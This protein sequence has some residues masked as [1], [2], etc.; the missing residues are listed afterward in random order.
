MK[1]RVDSIVA[2]V[3][4]VHIEAFCQTKVLTVILLVGV[5]Y[6][7]NAVQG[8]IVFALVSRRIC[9]IVTATK[10]DRAVTTK[11]CR[12]RRSNQQVFGPAYSRHSA[13]TS[14]S[15]II[16]RCVIDGTTYKDRMTDDRDDRAA[17]LAFTSSH[18]VRHLQITLTLSNQMTNCRSGSRQMVDND[19]V[20]QFFL[21]RIMVS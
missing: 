6:D 18:S 2:V 10:G 12:R 1:G 8:V 9:I 11:H 14:L 13:S 21:Q 7:Y 5:H 16:I 15:S 20:L 4:V 19:N 3:V 17:D